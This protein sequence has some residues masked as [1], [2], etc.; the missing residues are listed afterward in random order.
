MCHRLVASVAR[1]G[2]NITAFPVLGPELS[3]KRMELLK[4]FPQTI[5]GSRPL[6]SGQ[7]R[8][9]TSKKAIDAAVRAFITK[10][11]TNDETR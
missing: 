2:G 5:A 6:E 1:P 7:E 9:S 3:A 10:R 8:S 4:G 11:S